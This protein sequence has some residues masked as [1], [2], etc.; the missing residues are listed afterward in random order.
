[1]KF[2]RVIKISVMWLVVLIAIILSALTYSLSTTNH[3][4]SVWLAFKSA[5]TA[6]IKTVMNDPQSTFI[7]E[8]TGQMSE[9]SLSGDALYSNLNWKVVETELYNNLV[10]P[11]SMSSTDWRKEFEDLG[12]YHLIALDVFAKQYQLKIEIN[13]DFYKIYSENFHIVW[14]K[15]KGFFSD[16]RDTLQ[17]FPLPVTPVEKNEKIY[18]PVRILAERF[19]F[20]TKFEDGL[21]SIAIPEPNFSKL[22][23]KLIKSL[24]LNSSEVSLSYFHNAYETKDAIYLVV[25]HTSDIYQFNKPNYEFE[26]ISI[27]SKYGYLGHIHINEDTNIMHVSTLGGDLLS[28]DM[29]TEEIK[30]IIGDGNKRPKKIGTTVNLDDLNLLWIHFFV[31][32]EN[33]KNILYVLSQDT[34]LKVNLLANQATVIAD[35]STVTGVKYLGIY[36]GHPF[37]IDG[38]PDPVMTLINPSSYVTRTNESFHSLFKGERIYGARY[39]KK[40]DRWVVVISS[41]K[42]IAEVV[43]P[44]KISDGAAKVIRTVSVGDEIAFLNNFGDF[45]KFMNPNEDKVMVIDSD[46]YNLV[47]YT[48]GGSLDVLTNKELIGEEEK[49]LLPIGLLNRGTDLYIM[50]NLSQRVFRYSL[51]DDKITPFIGN[52]SPERDYQSGVHRLDIGIGYSAFIAEDENKNIMVADYFNRRI[53][54]IENDIASNLFP[55]PHWEHSSSIQAFARVGGE[56]FYVDPGLGLIFRVRGDDPLPQKFAGV[57]AKHGDGEQTRRKEA[58]LSYADMDHVDKVRF[59]YIQGIENFKGKLLVTDQYRHGIWEIDPLTGSVDVIA[60]MRAPTDYHYGGFVG[61]TG[62]SARDLRLGGLQFLTY[63]KERDILLLPS[64]YGGTLIAISGD[65]KKTIELV[66][67]VKIELAADA[68]FIGEDK[69]A[70]SDTSRNAVHIFNVSGL[71]NHLNSASGLEN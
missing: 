41:K 9:V 3:L 39:L 30:E 12:E 44:E 21:I 22:D 11:V 27:P 62:L 48:I 67:D 46:G 69:V 14:Q 8:T 52:G 17:S 54:K 50:A 60:G 13:G 57:I 15:G 24:S 43:M 1:M 34:I 64:Q 31:F 23:M 56:Y 33:D 35:A 47:Y 59:G 18:F 5:L 55:P 68:V 7:R 58:L 40:F 16:S 4:N 45:S 19:G 6:S 26:K 25:D 38:S 49:V 51:L 37:V 32:D 61:N 65:L 66:P 63:D 28:Y 10:G 2:V 36:R 53:L 29:V 70:V 71:R 42:Q 20:L